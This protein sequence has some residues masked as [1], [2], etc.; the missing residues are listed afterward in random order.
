M[1]AVIAVV[2]LFHLIYIHSKRDKTEL[3]GKYSEYY[4]LLEA[5]ADIPRSDDLYARTIIQIV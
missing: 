4:W 2:L 3:F 1:K 5:K